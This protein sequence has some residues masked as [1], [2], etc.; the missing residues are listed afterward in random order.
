MDPK[1]IPDIAPNVMEHRFNIDPC[2]K[3][4]IQKKRHMGPKR[5]AA[6]SAEVQKLLEV[7]FIQEC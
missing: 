1:K 7:G 2:H 5:V 4:V 3:P 6:A